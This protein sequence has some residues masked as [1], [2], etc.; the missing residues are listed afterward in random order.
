MDSEN[1]DIFNKKFK[2]IENKRDPSE[3]R[4]HVVAQVS[5][6]EAGPVSCKASLS[7]Q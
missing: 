3:L 4:L 1:L 7:C 6:H 2:T 5:S